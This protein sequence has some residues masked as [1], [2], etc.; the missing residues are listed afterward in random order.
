MKQ[1]LTTCEIA[2]LHTDIPCM[3]FKLDTI[4]WI[5][6]DDV[7]SLIELAYKIE[8]FLKECERCQNE[9]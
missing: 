6:V 4:R 2:K 7:K 1:I 3:D 8:V 9:I 5:K